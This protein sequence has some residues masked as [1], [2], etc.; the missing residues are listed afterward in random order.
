MRV[1]KSL[2]HSFI[3]DVA[4]GRNKPAGHHILSLEG[5]PHDGAIFESSR[6]PE[7]LA[8][9]DSAISLLWTAAIHS[10]AAFTIQSYARGPQVFA[11]ARPYGFTKYLAYLDAVRARPSWNAH[12]RLRREVPIVVPR[13]T[14]AL[15]RPLSSLES[16]RTWVG[17]NACPCA[18]CPHPLGPLATPNAENRTAKAASPQRSARRARGERESI[19]QRP[20]PILHSCAIRDSTPLTLT[21]ACQA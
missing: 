9:R 21:L 2:R 17:Q 7:A 5:T 1:W 20:I 18:G 11:H 4:A 15:I 16:S 10:Q 6:S 12:P 8:T 14:C 19:P 13:E 3:S